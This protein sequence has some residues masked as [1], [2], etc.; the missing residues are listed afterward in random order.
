MRISIPISQK[1]LNCMN[2]HVVITLENLIYHLLE[3][4]PV[5]KI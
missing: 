2:D 1:I 4:T 3:N 5:N